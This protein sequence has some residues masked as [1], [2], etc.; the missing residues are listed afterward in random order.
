[1]C[2]TKIAVERQL[3]YSYEYYNDS[4]LLTFL[5]VYIDFI[6]LLKSIKHAVLNIKKKHVIR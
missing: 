4:K 3:Y 5:F 1:M 2:T 6:L